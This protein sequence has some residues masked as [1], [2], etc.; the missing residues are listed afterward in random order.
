MF[1][2]AVKVVTCLCIYVSAH[3]LREA[4]C[5]PKMYM[6]VGIYMISVVTC[7]GV[8]MSSSGPVCTRTCARVCW[9]S[10][11]ANS[12]SPFVSARAVCSLRSPRGEPMC[13]H[14]LQSPLGSA[15]LGPRFLLI[16]FSAESL[17]PGTVPGALLCV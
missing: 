2:Q 13:V 7:G 8:C 3:V 6:R 17:T 16:L 11:D 5:D 12:M 9:H 10:G 15:L 4:I 1:V 14:M